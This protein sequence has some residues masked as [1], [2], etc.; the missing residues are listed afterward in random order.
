MNMGIYYT[1]T[2]TH[3]CIYTCV[4]VCSISALLCSDS[5]T[6]SGSF[7]LWF[8]CNIQVCLCDCK[9]MYVCVSVCVC[10]CQCM[11][12]YVWAMHYL[13]WSS[14]KWRIA[15]VVFGHWPTHRSFDVRLE[16]TLL[17]ILISQFTATNYITITTITTIST[18]TTTNTITTAIRSECSRTL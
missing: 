12:M 6:V 10:V 8:S 17:G 18:I 13:L 9:C 7:I 2:Q 1:C 11:C 15:A 4:H 3:T 16:A 14:G 5:W